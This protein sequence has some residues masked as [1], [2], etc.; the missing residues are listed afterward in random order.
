[1]YVIPFPDKMSSVL[2]TNILYA[3][4][5]VIYDLHSATDTTSNTQCLCKSRSSLHQISPI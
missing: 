1:M 2:L 4:G 3:R 5:Y